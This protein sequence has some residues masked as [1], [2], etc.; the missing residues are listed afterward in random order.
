MRFFIVVYYYFQKFLKKM[1]ISPK[2]QN[3]AYKICD[4][5]IFESLLS[6]Y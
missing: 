4:F 6:V 5:V 2:C 1:L 3:G